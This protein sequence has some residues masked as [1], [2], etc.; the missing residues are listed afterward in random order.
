MFDTNFVRS[1]EA[2]GL[3]LEIS[4]YSKRVTKNHFFAPE[5]VWEF[6]AVIPST[7]TVPQPGVPF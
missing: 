1:L 5:I 2:M 6:E 4:F 7:I 3:I